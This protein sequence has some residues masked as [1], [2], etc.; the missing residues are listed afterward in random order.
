MRN[1]DPEIWMQVKMTKLYIS[2]NNLISHPRVQETEAS[3]TTSSKGLHF[4]I[5]IKAHRY[6]IN[7][8]KIEAKIILVTV[9]ES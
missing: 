1:L 6:V 3:Q 8:M 5:N 9:A 2:L 7:F 4:R